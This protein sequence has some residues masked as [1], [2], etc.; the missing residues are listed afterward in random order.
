MSNS[1]IWPI[2]RTLSGATTLGQSGPG[3][4]GN[5]GVLHFPQIS[6]ISGTSPSDCLVSYTGHSWGVLRLCRVG[7]FCSPSRPDKR[8]LGNRFV[9]LSLKSPIYIF[10]ML[11]CFLR[12]ECTWLNTDFTLYKPGKINKLGLIQAQ[13]LG[14]PFI[15]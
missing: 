15:Q 9:R 4:D 10:K 11:L 7:V 5:E 14:Y 12:K 3:S 13:S 6:S 8:I 1:S 2:D